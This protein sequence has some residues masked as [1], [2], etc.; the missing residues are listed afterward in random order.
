MALF[1]EGLP[2]G[3]RGAARVLAFVLVLAAAAALGGER[4][5]AAGPAPEPSRA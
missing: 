3:W 1:A 4:P 5:P 2:P